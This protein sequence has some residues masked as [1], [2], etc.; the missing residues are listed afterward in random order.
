MGDM[1]SPITS[2][3]G[4]SLLFKRLYDGYELTEIEIIRVRMGR[5]WKIQIGRPNGMGYDAL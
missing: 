3:R 5:S 2:Q 4:L 1:Q